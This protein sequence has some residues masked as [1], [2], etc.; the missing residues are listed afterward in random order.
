MVRI[1]LAAVAMPAMLLVSVAVGW[2]SQ[3]LKTDE[4]PPD[5]LIILHRGACEHRCP[6]YNVIVFSD[7]TALFDGRSYVRRPEV[8]RTQVGR[9]VVRR[10]LDEA[11]HLHLFDLKTRYVPGAEQECSRPT[12]DA[13][14]SVV[15]VS[16]GGRAKIILHYQGCKEHEAGELIQ[17]EQDID[18]AVDVGNWTR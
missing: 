8:I 1:S 6:V 9:G 2:E 10:L 12:S 16:A 7:G 14:T 5:T 3:I 17:F 13:P 18:R 15:S 4:L 11:N